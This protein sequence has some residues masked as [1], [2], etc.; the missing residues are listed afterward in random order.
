MLCNFIE[1]ALRHGC[2]P[3]NLLHIFRTSFP[4]NTSGGLLLLYKFNA[5]M[6]SGDLLFCL[7]MQDLLVQGLII[8]LNLFKTYNALVFCRQTLA[9]ALPLFGLNRRKELQ[10]L[11]RSKASSYSMLKKLNHIQNAIEIQNPINVMLTDIKLLNAIAL[12]FECLFEVA[13]VAMLF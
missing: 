2:S 6:S 10:T 7:I 9:V 11:N 4:K 5:L 1:I 8:N 13:I 12:G 3:V